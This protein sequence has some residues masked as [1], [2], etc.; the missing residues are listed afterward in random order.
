MTGHSWIL[1]IGTPGL[2]LF[3]ACLPL[4]FGQGC[5]GSGFPPFTEPAGARPPGDGSLTGNVPPSLSFTAPLTDLAAE[6][7]DIVAISW[8]AEDP[9]NRASITILLDPDRQFGNGNE[10]VV[11]P[12]ATTENL[13][14]GFNLA[15]A[16]LP[17]A[18]YRII[19]RLSDGVN[20]NVIV[21]APG[22]LLLYGAGLAPGNVG[23]TIQVTAPSIN[24]GVSQGD[25]VT[26]SY[27]GRDP[28]DDGRTP[29]TAPSIVLLLDFDNDPTNDLEPLIAHLEAASAGFA[30]TYD[31]AYV[32][33]F[34][35]AFGRFPVDLSDLAIALSLQTGIPIPAALTT[36]KCIILDCVPDND[37]GVLVPTPRLDE[38][39]NPVEDDD[40][41]PIFDLVPTPATDFE[42]EVDVGAIP[43]RANGDPY[44]IRATMSDRV[45]RPVHGYGRGTLSVTQ[46]GSGVIDLRQVGRTVSGS[47]FIGFD[48]GSR[49]GSGGIGVG[50]MDGD[51]VDDF[52]ILSMFGGQI[53]AGSAHLVLG[54]PDGGKFG[55]EVPLTSITTVYRGSIFLMPTTTGT[56]GLV[57]AARMGDVTDD[58]LPDML[59][60][61]PYVEVFPHLHDDDPLDCDPPVCYPDL[62]PNPLSLPGADAFNA[63]MTGYD[64]R[65]GL[66]GEE[67]SQFVCSHDLDLLRTTPIDGGY[68][69]LIASENSL[70]GSVYNTLWTGAI[71]TYGSGHY[72]A[73]FRGPWYDAPDLSQTV[74][75]NWLSPNNRF[76]QTVATMPPMTNTSLSIS[77]R[78]GT[79][80]LISA[81]NGYEGRGHITITP[82]NNFINFTTEVLDFPNTESFPAYSDDF[83]LCTCDV[84]CRARTFPGFS[85]IVGA[86]IGDELGY[87][88]AAGD[89]NLDGSRDIL[90]GAPG[91]EREGMNGR[92][93]VY[94]IFGRPDWSG[95]DL[96]LQNPPRM[97]I[98]GTS[99]DDRFGEVQ[100]I[101]GDLNQDGLPDIGFAS[102]WADG[103][104]GIDS[105]FIGVVFGGR[106]LTGENVFTVD[107]VGTPELP[108]FRIHG[109]QPG[110]HAGAT[111]NTAGDF[112]GDGTDDMVI[113]APNEERTIDGITRVGVAYLIFGGSHLS[114]RQFNLSQVGSP[115]L[116]GMVFVSPYAKGSAEEAPIDWINTAGDINDDGFADILV[117]V[118]QA[119]F[120]N[121]LS[122]SQRRNNVGEMYLLYGNNVGSNASR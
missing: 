108:G 14:G 48:A 39:G 32:F 119:D 62:R 118:S 13:L 12:A 37:C 84:V 102:Q 97:E 36:D 21:V 96:G 29:P 99:R 28:D 30:V 87:A 67:D 92:G 9:D 65:E 57:A 81:P 82:N 91:A 83:G 68:A 89:Y 54:L 77:P 22:R 64:W 8:T 107:Q 45:N 116:P 16:T 55:S 69:F 88:S 19:A 103:P 50:D 120:V 72:G 94:I 56:N 43:P 66:A 80:L 121:P 35:C 71:T 111:L 112:N 117:G 4:L 42:L 95:L 49:A 27:C 41:N 40:G 113:V 7:G 47:K 31:G 98:W 6:V 101:V 61:A 109:T 38:N 73:I 34:I 23:P 110:G 17:P 76:G 93:I 70:S 51:G 10:I 3:V 90:C 100:T 25:D 5:P 115:D 58:G 46:L 86:A 15:T 2:F 104:G 79:T 122:P 106:R 75:P 74:T 59:L 52:V 20:P 78:Y 1:R 44:Y 33:D 26:I 63:A 60:G 53:N 105:G 11:L 18:T 24:L 114:N 85:T